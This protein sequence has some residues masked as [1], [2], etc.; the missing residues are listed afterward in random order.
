MSLSE[1]TARVAGGGKN[2]LKAILQKLG[3]AVGDVPIDQYADLADQISEKLFPDNLLDTLTAELFGLDSSAVPKDVFAKIGTALPKISGFAKIETGTYVGTGENSKTIN[4]GH[5]SEFIIVFYAGNEERAEGSWALFSMN[6]SVSVPNIT[7]GSVGT[8][9]SLKLNTV[10]STW[11]SKSVTFSTTYSN[12]IP[13][14]QG[15]NYKYVSF[16]AGGDLQ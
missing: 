4:L 11:K 1:Q 10:K 5:T 6:G 2:T 16:Y 12:M 7:L 8:D 3:V 14:A 9:T 13:N 15:N